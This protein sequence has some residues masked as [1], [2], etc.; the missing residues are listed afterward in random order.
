MFLNLIS[1]NLMIA[2][3]HSGS[4]FG[5]FSE[6]Q[7]VE[8][9]WLVWHVGMLCERG[10]LWFRHFSCA[11]STGYQSSLLTFMSTEYFFTAGTTL[12][13]VMFLCCSPP[14]QFLI[15]NLGCVARSF[16]HWE[17][18][19]IW[20]LMMHGIRTFLLRGR[21]AVKKQTNIDNEQIVAFYKNFH[22]LLPVSYTH[23]TLPTKA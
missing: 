18:F 14:S 1:C 2:R 16:G 6:V 21:F 22:I 20:G 9:A 23:L 19:F 10:F 12:L 3:L 15:E 5:H 17:P 7:T 11:L 4:V 8:G 13:T